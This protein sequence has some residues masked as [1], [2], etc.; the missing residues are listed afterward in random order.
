MVVLGYACEPSCAKDGSHV[1][2]AQ[3]WAVELRLFPVSVKQK[4][5]MT[6]DLKACMHTCV[7]YLPQRQFGL[8]GLPQ[9]PEGAA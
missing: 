9:I 4:L 7:V 3:V 6:K 5:H 8:C 1:L 2:R